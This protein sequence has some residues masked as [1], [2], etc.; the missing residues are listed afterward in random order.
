MVDIILLECA[1]FHPKE[2]PCLIFLNSNSELLCIHISAVTVPPLTN[3]N[4][5]S[6]FL[7]RCWRCN[8]LLFFLMFLS[9]PV[10][11]FWVQLPCSCAEDLKQSNDID[12]LLQQQLSRK[13]SQNSSQHSVSSHRSAHTDSPVHSSL[14][15]ALSESN[16]PPP[17]S[18]P[19]PGLPIQ[20]SPGDGTIQRKPDPFKIWAQSRS[21]YESRRKYI[22][23]W[24]RLDE[25]SMGYWL[26]ADPWCL[27]GTAH[28]GERFVLV[29]KLGQIFIFIYWSM[30]Y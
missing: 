8:N 25:G 21:M 22:H 5:D 20:D 13:D 16:A 4:P 17:P 12:L 10:S 1:S 28:F 3:H 30:F 29:S 24:W 14:A 7:F 27:G 6:Y 11:H 9:P 23:F 2:K 15:P 19:L 26:G 18:Q